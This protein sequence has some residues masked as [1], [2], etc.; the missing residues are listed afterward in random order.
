M[1]LLREFGTRFGVAAVDAIEAGAPGGDDSEAATILPADPALRKAVETF[2]VDAVVA[3]LENEYGVGRVRRMP[4]N[5][6]GYDLESIGRRTLS[7]YT[8]K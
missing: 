8:S 4:P 7:R 1:W 5:N 6:P 3:E 2:A